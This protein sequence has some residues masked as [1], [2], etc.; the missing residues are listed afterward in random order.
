MRHLFIL[1]KWSFRNKIITKSFANSGNF[2]WYFQHTFILLS[3]L[4]IRN[5]KIIFAILTE[6]SLKSG[7]GSSG[8]QQVHFYE[9][10]RLVDCKL[11]HLWDFQTCIILRHICIINLSYYSRTTVPATYF[12]TLHIMKMF[13]TFFSCVTINSNRI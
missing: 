8:V 4:F 12:C 10:L 2:S 5:C 1:S 11:N 13:K 3:F 6:Y 7:S 9:S